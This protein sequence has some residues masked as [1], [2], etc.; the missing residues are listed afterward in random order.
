MRPSLFQ[1]SPLAVLV[2]SVFSA[3]V[4]AQSATINGVVL[5]TDGKAIEQARVHVHGRQQYVYADKNG[6]FTIQAPA[7]AELHIS[8]KGYGD[9]FVK[10]ADAQNNQLKI[11]LKPVVWNVIVVAA[12][13]LHHYDLEMAN[14][15]SVLSGEELSR[16]TE[17]TIGETLK[18]MPGV[19]SNYYGP[20]AASPILRGLD[21]PRVRILSNGLR[22]SRRITYRPRSRHQ[23]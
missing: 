13:G 20:V 21:G 2:A 1:L 19:H 10:V 6:R 5:D 14:P 7:D 8:A 3:Q 11:Q 23:C 15:V 22:F 17:P 4:R 16:K 9:Q 12:S 18:S